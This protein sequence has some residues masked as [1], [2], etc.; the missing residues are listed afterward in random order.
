[1]GLGVRGEARK[2]K[3]Q[4]NTSSSSRTFAWSGVTIGGGS[5]FA[6]E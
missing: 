5:E 1:L 3:K 6:L 4:N 2:G